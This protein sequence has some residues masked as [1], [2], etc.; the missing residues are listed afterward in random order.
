MISVLKRFTSQLVVHYLVD[1][2]TNRPNYFDGQK[3]PKLVLLCQKKQV[4]CNLKLQVVYLWWSPYSSVIVSSFANVETW[5]NF[6]LA[7]LL[8]VSARCLGLFCP[9]IAIPG[10][11][12]QSWDPGLRNFQ[13]RDT[14]ILFREDQSISCVACIG[15]Q[16]VGSDCDGENTYYIALQG[17][18]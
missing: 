18:E 14:W 16:T 15:P 13:S 4:T 7:C 9:V 5:F 11:N 10:L 1:Q 17:V 2:P 3:Y 12:S 6:I 8:D